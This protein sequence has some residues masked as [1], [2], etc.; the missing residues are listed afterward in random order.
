MRRLFTPKRLNR[1][2]YG[3][4]QVSGKPLFLTAAYTMQTESRQHNAEAKNVAALITENQLGKNLVWGLH[5]LY[6]EMR[7]KQYRGFLA[8]QLDSAKEKGDVSSFSSSKCAVLIAVSN[9]G[10]DIKRQIGRPARRLVP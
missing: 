3:T 4:A 8:R 10:Q 6:Y 7:H 2:E 1:S 9:R 5:L